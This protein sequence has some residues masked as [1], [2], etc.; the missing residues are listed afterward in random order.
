LDVKIENANVA[1]LDFKSIVCEDYISTILEK[2]DKIMNEAET[3]LLSEQ[4]I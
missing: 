3:V 2:D 1:I 4:F